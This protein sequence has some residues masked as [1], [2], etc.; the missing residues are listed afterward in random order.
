M[1]FMLSIIFIIKG[2]KKIFTQEDPW[3]PNKK[4]GTYFDRDIHFLESHNNEYFPT[5]I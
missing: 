3:R 1:M 4:R 5:A 2:K